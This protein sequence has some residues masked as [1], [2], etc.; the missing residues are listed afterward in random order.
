[1][2]WTCQNSMIGRPTSV[3]ISAGN[4][5]WSPLKAVI[6]TAIIKKSYRGN[7][8]AL[9]LASSYLTQ[10]TDGGRRKETAQKSQAHTPAH[11]R[12]F[13]VIQLAHKAI[14]SRGIYTW[15]THARTE[16]STPVHV[17]TTPT[18]RAC[19]PR[20]RRATTRTTRSATDR[21]G[22]PLLSLTT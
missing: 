20:S 14:H 2:S 5:S 15:S 17:P 8:T 3:R 16:R 13:S 12:P 7:L 22:C 18:I 10:P 9:A 1:M 21:P 11:T 4:Y 19:R 6:C